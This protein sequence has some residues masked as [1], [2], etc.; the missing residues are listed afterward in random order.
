MEAAD[1]A[2]SAS[3]KASAAST[4]AFQDAVI[5]SLKLG[6]RIAH[7]VTKDPPP[8]LARVLS[9]NGKLVQGEQAVLDHRATAWHQIWEGQVG[10]SEEL[11]CE[12]QRLHA[13]AVASPLPPCPTHP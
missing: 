12:L 7:A 2:A 4:A 10:P 3:K 8:Q 9:V 5:T 11:L 6:G 1:H 13:D